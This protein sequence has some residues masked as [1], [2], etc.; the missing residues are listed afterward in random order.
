VLD[1]APTRPQVESARDERR[2]REDEIRVHGFNWHPVE[3][4]LCP[5]SVYGSISKT[6]FMRTRARFACRRVVLKYAIRTH[7]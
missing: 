5:E 2:H 7:K 4:L 6:T 1:V 3:G